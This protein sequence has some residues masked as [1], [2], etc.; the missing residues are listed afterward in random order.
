M[1]KHPFEVS[2]RLDPSDGLH[3]AV[4]DNDANVGSGVTLRL[5]AQH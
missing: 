3:K 1:S 4:P 2:S 5:F